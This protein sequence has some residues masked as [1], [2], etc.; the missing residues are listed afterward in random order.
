MRIIGRTHL[1]FIL[2]NSLRNK[3]HFTTSPFLLILSPAII[4]LIDQP[5][6]HPQKTFEEYWQI[7]EERMQTFEASL[8][9]CE[10]RPHYSDE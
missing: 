3:H 1:F 2:I 9:S 8:H 4:I 7:F 6:L 5:A 10:G